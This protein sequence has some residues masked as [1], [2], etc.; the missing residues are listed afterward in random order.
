MI[1]QTLFLHSEYLS[2]IAAIFGSQMIITNQPLLLTLFIVFVVSLL[3]QL[4]FYLLFYLAPVF[5]RH[6]DNPVRKDPVSVI[7]CARNEEENLK[8]F[9]PAVM[10]QDYPGFEV[11]VVNDC[12]EDDSYNVLGEFLKK[13]PNL[14][15]SNIIKDPNSHIIKSLPSLLALRLQKMKC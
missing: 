10:E 15:V 2:N 6:T 13:Y 9:L 4:V 1:P 12:S 5:Y 3:V 7:I 8:N 14:H 11:I